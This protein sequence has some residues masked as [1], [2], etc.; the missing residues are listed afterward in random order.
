MEKPIAFINA[1]FLISIA[2]NA[3]IMFPMAADAFHL[4]ASVA[5][6]GLA[7]SASCRPD[8]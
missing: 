2:R 5:G 8:R 4:V 1:G 7:A 3:N 6:R